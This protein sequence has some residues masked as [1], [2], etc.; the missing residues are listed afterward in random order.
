[1]GERTDLTETSPPPGGKVRA[2][3]AARSDAK[4]MGSSERN[5]ERA[6][7]VQQSA[8]EVHELTKAGKLAE[9]P[10][11]NDTVEKCDFERC[12]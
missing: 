9:L 11:S 12:W 1:M 4:D 7:F 5:V 3:S 8:P 6:L 2:T 10:T